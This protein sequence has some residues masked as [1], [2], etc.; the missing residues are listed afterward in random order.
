MA[1]C[2]HIVYSWRELELCGVCA[3]EAAGQDMNVESLREFRAR[4]QAKG[5]L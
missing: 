1:G 5:L 4:L 2:G 3:A